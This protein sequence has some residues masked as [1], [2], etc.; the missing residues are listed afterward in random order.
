MAI[1]DIIK[2]DEAGGKAPAVRHWRGLAILACAFLAGLG[3]TPARAEYPVE[4]A[5]FAAVARARLGAPR[6]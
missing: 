3:L 5:Y 4:D 1:G 2:H 6:P